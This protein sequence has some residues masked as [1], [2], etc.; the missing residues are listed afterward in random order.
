MNYSRQMAQSG[1]LEQQ[2]Y[3][4]L[5]DLEAENIHFAVEQ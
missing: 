3:S 1:D 4:Q 2:A 5:D